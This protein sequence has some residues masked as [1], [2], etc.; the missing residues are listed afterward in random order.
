MKIPNILIT[1]QDKLKFLYRAMELLRLEHNERGKMF[2]EGKISEKEFRD[3]QNGEFNQK[4]EKI[5]AELNPLKE[6][7]GLFQLPKDNLT[8]TKSLLKQQGM[9]ETKWDKSIS[10]I[11]I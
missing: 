9:Q 6:K 1:N 8:D 3:Y 4:T 11:N 10:L 2:R 5:F 7:L